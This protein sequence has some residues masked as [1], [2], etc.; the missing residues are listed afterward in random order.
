MAINMITTFKSKWKVFFIT[1]LRKFNFLILL[2]CSIIH[3]QE[4]LKKP[5][6]EADYALWG[7]LN[8]HSISAKGNWVSY[9]MQYDEV[10]D[11]LFVEN[12]IGIKKHIIA[13]AAIGQ[14]NGENQFA[15]LDKNNLLY[16]IDLDKGNVQT[17]NEVKSYVF[18]SNGTYLIT[19]QQ[20][21]G[22]NNLYIRSSLGKVL[23][24]HERVTEF[25]MNNSQDAMVCVVE[26]SG[27]RSVVLIKLGTSISKIKILDDNQT[28]VSNL[29]WSESDATFAFLAQYKDIHHTRL[30]NYS[31]N[32]NKLYNLSSNEIMNFAE[33][34]QLS[35]RHNTLTISPDDKRVIFGIT[36]IPSTQLKYEPVQLWNGNDPVVYSQKKQQG[37]LE[38]Q[39]QIAVW[40]PET[41]TF[42]KITDADRPHCILNNSKDFALTY[43]FKETPPQYTM[44]PK[45]NYYV[46]N[47]QTNKQKLL[48]E[49]QS[50]GLRNSSMSPKGTYFAYFHE[51]SWWVY[52]FKKEKK[53][54]L[55]Q[56]KKFIYT[57]R[58]Y[59]NEIGA[60]GVAGWSP[61]DD[62]LLLYDEYDIWRVNFK[63]GNPVRL[64]KGREKNMSFKIIADN[65]K[66]YFPY[67]GNND[68]VIN[69][70]KG[71]LLSATSENET[72]YF[73]LRPNGL[74]KEI[75]WSKS[76]HSKVLK[77]KNTERILF[78]SQNYNKPPQLIHYD[79]KSNKNSL[80]FQSNK[81][82]FN[83]QWSKQDI[84]KYSN[85][86]NESLSGLLY[87][88]TNYDSTREYPMIVF[89]YEEQNYRKHYYTN[90]SKSSMI[91]FNVS[92]LASKGCFVLLPD[93]KYDLGNPGLSA[94]ECVIAATNKVINSG[95]VDKNRIALMGQSFGGY[96][97]NFIVTQT[98]MF[99]TAVSGVSIF[100]LNSMY[101][102][103]SA[104]SGM[105]EHWRFESQQWRMGKS[106]FK[107]RKSYEH[108]SPST[109]VEKITTPI[110]LWCGEADRQINPDQSIAM[111]LALRRLKKK[112]ILLMYPNESHS[113]MLKVN[114]NDLYHRIDDWFAF[115][116]KNE[117]PAD[118]IK[119]GIN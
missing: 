107:D 43:S 111:Y 109:Y 74:I 48:I 85:L 90:P 113:L 92:S 75:I 7:K 10:P 2:I 32:Q 89:I 23:E 98:N 19:L 25:K 3:S 96:E 97:T 50:T 11:T 72:G 91:G 77:S 49:N 20:E 84:I 46:N 31:L 54:Q 21:K 95:M 112:S 100:D 16:L 6:T 47:L 12:I 81:H 38:H 69:L 78:L 57:N 13:D 117:P 14:F 40:C 94:T 39:I 41:G 27:V 99:R 67:S 30:Y 86:K 5:V 8:N 22:E 114:Q 105:P 51:E 61:N 28:I 29:V 18:T 59:A 24:I 63:G 119:N 60:F 71:L 44:T 104:S 118:W 68:P 45:V 55:P 9:Q 4:Q 82:H 17:I 83:Y 1:S 66:N 116:L 65:K 110:L 26:K 88:P 115:Y 58:E 36:K 70:S 79:T 103:L 93:I 64:T 108:N 102:S 101:L 80:I 37:D 73:F 52:D 76:Y 33:G 62:Y 53:T 56:R 42:S 87:Y 106:L 35:T 34:F 15:C